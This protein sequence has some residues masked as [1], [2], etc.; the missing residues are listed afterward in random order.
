MFR[1]V[2][3]FTFWVIILSFQIAICYA[4][5]RGIHISWNGN[6]K[7]ETATTM[8][9][10]WLNDK[11]DNGVVQYGTKAGNL[12]QKISAIEVY[13]SAVKT[14]ISKV[15]LL[16]LKP[17]TYY[18]Y[19]VGSDKNGWSQQYKFRTAPVDGD[20]SK[21]LIG[22]WSDTQNNA[23][24][25]DFEQTDTIIKQMGN[26]PYN[27]TIHT[28]DIVEN[29]SVAKNWNGYFNTA[30]V[31]NATAPLMSVS[32]NHDVVNDTA[33]KIFQHPFPMFFELMNLPH[34]QL[35]YSYNYGNTHFVAINSGYAQG[36]EK[37]GKVLFAEDSDEY[38]WLEA[39]LRDA[40]QNENIKWVIVYSHYPLF[41]FGV[42]R[43]VTWHD[44]I[45]PLIDKYKVDL[46]IAGHRHV[47]E[48]HKTIR[49]TQIFEQAD[50]HIYNLPRG[51]VY[52]NNGSF[53]G[54]LQG[55]GG[56]DMPDMLFTPRQ[57]VYTYAVMSI[58]GN[59]IEYK[60]FDKEGR[61]IDYFKIIKN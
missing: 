20:K 17:A 28:G 11:A 26:T 40:R 43:I 27:F 31:I 59:T 4:Q 54:S 9:I 8:G 41:A 60:V 1:I 3:S 55:V 37:V 56:W 52:I 21:I 48:R 7:V 51:T 57:K 19:K 24:N 10:T 15:T 46:Y 49:G 2:Q 12:D 23:G 18:Y 39:D 30:Q 35:N 44:H 38:R 29:G 16:K 50:T 47:Y 5:P 36:A 61:P 25:L 33:S 42:S 53:G 32:G 34:D 22:L 14:Y 58:E 6:T 45:Q 13:S